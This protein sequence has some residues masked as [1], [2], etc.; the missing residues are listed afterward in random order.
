LANIRYRV[1]HIRPDDCEP[2]PYSSGF[3]F[4]ENLEQMLIGELRARGDLLF[5]AWGV[6]AKGCCQVFL[7]AYQ[8]QAYKAAFP[9]QEMPIRIGMDTTFAPQEIVAIM[10]NPKNEGN[11]SSHLAKAMM[12]RKLKKWNN[13]S[14][15]AIADASS[16]NRV[17]VAHLKKLLSLHSEVKNLLQSGKISYSIARELIP[18]AKAEQ[19]KLAR[20]IVRVGMDLTSVRAFLGKAATKNKGRSAAASLLFKDKSSD[21]KRLEEQMS[22]T[23]N[24]QV[25]V[26]TK[27]D[28]S[29]TISISGFDKAS[30]E[31][32]I[33][34]MSNKTLSGGASLVLKFDDLD[35]F[36]EV[37]S[38]LL[39][40][41]EM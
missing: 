17:T 11:E 12:I 14:D 36:D 10:L 25:S 24:H 20:R 33:E 22:Q 29:G 38:N 1:I 5:P 27:N 30:L 32:L 8:I 13:F 7:G 35:K 21:I 15:Q 41:D 9:N 16:M 34:Q 40:S 39:P 19:L 23:I 2:A 37:S 3:S 6:E 26:D 4:P 28:G 18:V 31:G